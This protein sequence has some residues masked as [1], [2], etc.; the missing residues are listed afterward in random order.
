MHPGLPTRNHCTTQRPRPRSLVVSA[1]RSVALLPRRIAQGVFFISADGND[2]TNENE[3]ENDT[4]LSTSTL[5]NL[6]IT[7]AV[8]TRGSDPRLSWGMKSLFVGPK[9]PLSKVVGWM[10]A[11]RRLGACIIVGDFAAAAGYLVI[12]LGLTP[13]T[14]WLRIARGVPPVGDLVLA[15]LCAL[16]LVHNEKEKE[17]NVNVNEAALGSSERER[18]C[19]SGNGDGGTGRGYQGL[20]ISAVSH[21]RQRFRTRAGTGSGLKHV[22]N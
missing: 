2:K 1:P 9:D 17:R 3:S 15:R 22:V 12:E 14:A 13:R 4:S 20:G 6:E 19:T 10:R 5:A 18:E 11:V 21:R 8:V 7:H 16:A